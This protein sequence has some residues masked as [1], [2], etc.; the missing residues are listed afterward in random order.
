VSNQIHGGFPE[1]RIIDVTTTGERWPLVDDQGRN[2]LTTFLQITNPESSGVVIRIYTTLA[3]FTADA[4][5]ALTRGHF[6]Q[7]ESPGYW[8]GPAEVKEIWTR[9]IGGAGVLEYV[10]FRRKG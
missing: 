6:L 1:P 2:F 7:L 4:G 5:G 9:S 10:A 3:A 8:D